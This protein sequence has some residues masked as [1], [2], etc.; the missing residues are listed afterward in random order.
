MLK[1][2]VPLMTEMAILILEKDKS[3][4]RTGLLSVKTARKTF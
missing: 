2:R 4:G 1:V 3:S